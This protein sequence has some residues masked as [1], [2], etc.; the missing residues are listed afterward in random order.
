[1][2]S[3]AV[4]SVASV[5]LSLCSLPMQTEWEALE[6]TD[7]QWALDDVEEELMARDL[8]FEGMFKKELQ[9]SIF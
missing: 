3:P 1:M 6:L 2:L 9:T 8:H 7:H 5:L 4:S